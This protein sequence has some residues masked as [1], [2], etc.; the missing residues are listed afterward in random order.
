MTNQWMCTMKQV[1]DPDLGLTY[2]PVGTTGALNQ[3]ESMNTPL[4]L[5]GG[6]LM[7]GQTDIPV[8]FYTGNT[9]KIPNAHQTQMKVSDWAA[10][11]ATW[12]LYKNPPSGKHNYKVT[13]SL[14]GC[15]P[16][17][18]WTVWGFFSADG[19][20]DNLLSAFPLGGVPNAMNVGADGTAYF[21]REVD[22]N[23]WLK[24]GNPLA[25]SWHGPM[26]EMPHV[27]DTT[28][29]PKAT[30]HVD[31]LYHNTGQ[32]NGNAGYCALDSSGKCVNPPDPS[33]FMPGQFG[34]DIGPALT[35]AST[36]DGPS[37]T[38]PIPIGMVQPY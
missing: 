16:D 27:P 33:I 9:A 34:V 37:T 21:E 31:A 12:Q 32:S 1:T 19:T 22:P 20:Y 30:F 23:V 38:K 28:E 11:K 17:T 7:G 8:V 24:S 26:G 14:T 13:I 25:G 35:G 10:C 2:V 3:S 5:A 36:T 15:P 29:F 6:A 18:A 4:Y